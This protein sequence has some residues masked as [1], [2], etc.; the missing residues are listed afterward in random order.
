[1]TS[2]RLPAA[3][4]GAALLVA[5]LAGCSAIDPNGKVQSCLTLAKAMPS[6]TSAATSAM[7]DASSDPSKA[8]E[9]L[10]KA[11]DKLDKAIADVKNPE[12][13]KTAQTASDSLSEM[14]TELD[15]ALADPASADQDKLNASI[16]KM[17]DDFTAIDT[18][19][20][21]KS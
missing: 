9:G 15:A 10:K 8:V 19:C 17:E 16:K 14:T 21:A 20:G 1:M 18:V 3:L 2:L 7:S 12:V 6:I 13:K 11:N 4:A 5:A